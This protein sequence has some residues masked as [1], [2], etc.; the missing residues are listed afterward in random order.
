MERATASRPREDE[1]GG[2]GEEK[3]NHRQAKEAN[4]REKG[5]RWFKEGKKC[6]GLALNRLN[7]QRHLWSNM[8]R[9]IITCCY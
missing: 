9:K 8:E 4:G 5:K 7:G 3:Q 2:S 1:K 6:E